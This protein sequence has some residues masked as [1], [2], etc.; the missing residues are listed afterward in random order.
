MINFDISLYN[1]LCNKVKLIIFSLAVYCRIDCIV[2]WF[3]L[4]FWASNYVIDSH[5][6]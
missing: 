3:F 4:S 5:C 1:T 6:N 2:L